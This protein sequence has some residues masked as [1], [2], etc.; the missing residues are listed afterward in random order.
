MALLVDIEKK[1]GDFTLQVNF[2]AENEIFALLGAS[3]CGKSLTLKC[4]AGIERPD[5]G[6]I[7]LDGRTLFDSDRGICLKPQQRR[8]GYLF[9]QYALFP[10]MTVRQNIACGLRYRGGGRFRASGT[11]GTDPGRQADAMQV[12]AMIARMQLQGLEDRKPAQLSGGQQQRTAL[13]RIL[14]NEPDIVMLDEPFSALDSHLRFHMEAEVTRQMRRY[15]KTVLLVSHDRDEVF[16]MSDSL[17]VMAE[18]RIV[19]AG[20]KRDVFLDPRT[21][22]GARMTGCKNIAPARPLDSRHLYVPAWGMELETDR[23]CREAAF[24]G[25][26]MHDIRL[27][28]DA[29]GPNCFRCRV[30]EVIENP[31]SYTILLRTG[32]GQETI[33]ME[34]D[35]QVWETLGQEEPIVCIPPE[36]VLILKA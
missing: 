3:G 33:G 30:A 25:I 10:H 2:R 18:G 21:E 35:R 34:T 19:A 28:G 5:R 6:K 14:I 13:A 26:R 1:L 24:A 22:A 11:A 27:C 29:A 15:G 17:A 32:R 36:S 31:F 9:Q 20:P 4:I 12:N 23:D 16:R 7:L 8:A